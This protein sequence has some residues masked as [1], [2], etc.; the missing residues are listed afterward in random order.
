[1]KAAVSRQFCVNNSLHLRK[2]GAR[3]SVFR[4]LSVALVLLAVFTVSLASHA[5]TS[6]YGSA[7]STSFGFSGQSYVSGT[8]LKPRTTGFI[9]GAFYTLPSLTR[10]K[11][12][13]DARYTF[14]PGY[15]GG[16]AS[17]AAIRLSFVPNDFLLRPYGEFGGGIASTQLHQNI[18][19]GT[20]C[21]QTT[22][23][24]TS[25]VVQFGGGLDIRLNRLF[26]IRALDYQYDTGG[27][28]G[29]THS[30]MHSF[31]SGLVFHLPSRRAAFR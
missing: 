30:A 7:V 3:L 9:T 10:F 11:T 5:Q 29:V 22:S 2:Q 26:D 6:V 17:T 15:N 27:R 19:T 31:S 25:G 1:M 13:L 28:A 12:S 8:Q 23:Q 16:K 14:A 24:L 18:C 21:R 20:T 4:N